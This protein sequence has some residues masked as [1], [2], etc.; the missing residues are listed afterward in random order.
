MCEW[1]YKDK[2]VFKQLEKSVRI[3]LDQDLPCATASM[4]LDTLKRLLEE[5]A[6]F[7]VSAI[8]IEWCGV[9]LKINNLLKD[10]EIISDTLPEFQ[11][12]KKIS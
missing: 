7:E 4:N 5:N 1:N 9:Q 2:P 11:K 3:I 6:L 10:R 12:E 8:K